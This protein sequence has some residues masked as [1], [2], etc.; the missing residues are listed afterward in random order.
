MQ[1]VSIQ[2]QAWDRTGL[3][4]DITSVLAN[5]H[6]NVTGVHTHSNKQDGTASMEIIVEVERLGQLGRLLARI[7][8]QPNVIA[9]RRM[10]TNQTPV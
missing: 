10:T 2:V 8:Q 3:L 7:E 4:R 9:A 6:V 5:E 1:P